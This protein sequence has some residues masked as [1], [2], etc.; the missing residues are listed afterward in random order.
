MFCLRSV[1]PRALAVAVLSLS[2][3]TACKQG[4]TGKA[5]GTAPSASGSAAK[6]ATTVCGQYSEKICA[7]AGA[8]SSTCAAFKTSADLMAPEACKAGLEKIDFSVKRL[9]TLKASCT[10]LTKLLCDKMGAESQSCG[11]VKEQTNKF[12]P[13]KC[14]EMLDHVP[15]IVAELEQMEAA[16]RPLS[17]QQMAPLLAGPVPAFGPENARVQIVEFSDFQCPFCSR[18]AS[19]VH[20]L[21]QKYEKDVRFVFRQFPLQMHPD[22]R[23]AAIASLE[24]DAQGKFWAFHDKLFENQSQLD[25]ASLEKHAQAVGLDMAKFKKALDDST[26]AAAVDRDLKLGE[27]VKVNGTPTIFLNGKRVQNATDFAAMSAEIDAELKKAASPG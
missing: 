4:Q 5:A 21:K 25:R 16:N 2:V 14:K 23:P 17:P 13:D 19:A 24:A 27:E 11:L 9:G 3:V 26:H 8:E 18:A 22:A 12:P 1:F 7:T 10:Q 6:T 15:E 20:Q